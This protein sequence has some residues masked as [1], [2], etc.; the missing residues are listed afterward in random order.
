MQMASQRDKGSCY[1]MQRE[2]HSTSEEGRSPRQTD[3]FIPDHR[4]LGICRHMESWTERR[5]VHVCSGGR[6]GGGGK[7]CFNDSQY[8]CVNPSL[9]WGALEGQVTT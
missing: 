5:R 6:S 3:L 8:A 9:V 1:L 2:T 4:H 7:N